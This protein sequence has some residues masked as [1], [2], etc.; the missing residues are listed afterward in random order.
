MFNFSEKQRQLEQIREKLAAQLKQK[1]DNEDERIHE[2]VR[3]AEEKRAKEELE[4]DGKMRVILKEEAEHRNI[5]VQPLDIERLVC[6]FLKWKKS[7]DT[8]GF[9]IQ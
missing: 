8:M 4:K 7:A 9:A 2:A 6:L 1:L 5:Q 3:E